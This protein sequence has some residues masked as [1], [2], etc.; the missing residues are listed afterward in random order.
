MLTLDSA[1]QQPA[2]LA[3][4]EALYA[5]KPL[6]EILLELPQEQLLHVAML[7]DMWELPSLS[8]AAAGQLHEDF[9][10]AGELEDAITQHLLTSDA[11]P[12]C[13]EPLLKVL[14]LSEF[15][16]LEAVWADE[17]LQQQ[18]LGLSLHAMKL[19]LSSGK[20]QVCCTQTWHIMQHVAQHQLALCYQVFLTSPTY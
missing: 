20:L 9:N 8:T 17:A 3:V 15:G 18:L 11:V 6:D 7:A 2:A 16:N 13:L 12:S 5:A 4:L 10:T 19:L 1:D 14:L